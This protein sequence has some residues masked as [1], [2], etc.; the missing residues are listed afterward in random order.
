MRS[1][2]ECCL[3]AAYNLQ[4]YLEDSAFNLENSHKIV[5]NLSY[6]P[7][8]YSLGGTDCLDLLCWITVC[9]VVVSNPSQYLV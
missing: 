9:A 8:N 7:T 4:V 6:E 1:D 3:L 5:E 2:H